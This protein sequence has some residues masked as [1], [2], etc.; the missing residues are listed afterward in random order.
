MGLLE[1]RL[2]DG[3]ARKV[4][5]CLSSCSINLKEVLLFSRRLLVLLKSHRLVKEIRTR[6]RLVH[7]MLL[8]VHGTHNA[9]TDLTLRLFLLALDLRSK[10]RVEPQVLVVRADIARLLRFQ[11]CH[12]CYNLS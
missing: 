4:D 5:S 10:S 9:A 3:R 1:P 7:G 11:V 12:S 8:S 6:V 2:A